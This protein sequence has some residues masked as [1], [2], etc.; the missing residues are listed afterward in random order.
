[1]KKFIYIY[2]SLIVLG[3]AAAHA[4]VV[5]T[6]RTTYDLAHPNNYLIDFNNFGPAGTFYPT[7]LS[8][9]SPGGNITFTGTPQ[10]P[11]SIEVLASTSFGISGI[12]NFVLHDNGGQFLA[13]SLLITLPANTFSFGTDIISPSQT[14]PEPYKFT[15]YSGSTVIGTLAPV[16]A[17]GSYTFTGFDSLSSP[18]TS[19]AVQIANALGNP[20]PVLDNFTVV[21]EPSTWLAAALAL[22]VIGFSQ[23]KRVRDSYRFLA[24]Y[25]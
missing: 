22:A 5:Y 16:S 8:A 14:V 24:S 6:S 15:I 4:Q 3:A 20:E 21:P 18:I 11:T 7:G 1:M 9:S 17:Y 12:G 10:T 25:F 19:I 23:R 2:V 13:D